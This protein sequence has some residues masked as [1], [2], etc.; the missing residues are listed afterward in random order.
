MGAIKVGCST[1]S[2]PSPLGEGDRL[3]SRWRLR[4][5][6]RLIVP[7]SLRISGS[8]I[9]ITKRLYARKGIK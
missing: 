4:I 9:S 5:R 3:C 7:E 8:S 2:L 1:S 6:S